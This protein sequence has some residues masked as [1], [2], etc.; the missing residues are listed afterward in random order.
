MLAHLS[1]I[2]S[3][4]PHGNKP[5]VAFTTPPN[6]AARISHILSLN[7]Y[8]PLWCPT[9]VVE[10][11]PHTISA[12][13]PY[14][15][16]H[17]LDHFSAIAFT[18]RTAIQA[19]SDAAVN[20]TEPPLSP[21]GDTF[22]IAA[23]G[24]DSELIDHTFVSKLCDNLERIRVLVPATATPSGL[25]D[26]LGVGG[27]RRVLCPVPLVV[28]LKEPP[29]VPNFMRELHGGGWVPVRVNAYETRW[30]GPRCAEGIVKRAEEGRLDVLIF[31]SSAEVEGLLK[32]LKEL[33]LDF[34]RLKNMCPQ[35]IVA[36]HG[37]VTKAGSERLGVKV[38]V[39]SSKFDSFDGVVH[40]IN[41]TFG[42]N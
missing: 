38:D 2:I 36:S 20:L 13:K 41:L 26:S 21:S 34:E 31:T 39:V 37:P 17:T 7:G 28:E 19:F 33:G 42:K 29:V 24:K 4:T 32:S 22:T 25:V 9:L 14:L 5:T 30:A 15:S 27:G 6:Y 16:P 35:L 1:S 18:S 10:P 8:N 3:M 40:S 11:T 12:L 23:L